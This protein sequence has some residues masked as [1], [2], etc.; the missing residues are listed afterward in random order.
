[1]SI[2]RRDCHRSINVLAQIVDCHM[3]IESRHYNMAV[4]VASL[5]LYYGMMREEFKRCLDCEFLLRPEGWYYI[6]FRQSLELAMHRFTQLGANF[7]NDAHVI[8]RVTLSPLAVA[9]YTS[10]LEE[11]HLNFMPILHKICHKYSNGDT[12]VWHFTRD[13]PINVKDSNDQDLICTELVNLGHVSAASGNP[14]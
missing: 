10:T 3:S 7:D 13:M 5:Q 1:M 4:P 11:G 14:C 2:H 12:G 8:V 9:Y 6:G